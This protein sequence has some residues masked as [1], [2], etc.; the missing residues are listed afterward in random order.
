MKEILFKSLEAGSV[1]DVSKSSRTVTG[2]FSSFGQ[3]PD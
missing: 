1:K 3:D 2:Y